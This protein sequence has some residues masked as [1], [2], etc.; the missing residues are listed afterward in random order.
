MSDEIHRVVCLGYPKDSVPDVWLTTIPRFLLPVLQIQSILE[1][2]T[3]SEIKASLGILSANLG[4]VFENTIQRIDKKPPNRRNAATQALMWVSHAGMPLQVDELCHALA[5]KLDGTGFDHDDLLPP[6]SIIECCFGLIVLDDESSTFR[7]VQYTLQDHLLSRGPQSFMQEETYIAQILITYVLFDGT[8]D[9]AIEHKGTGHR[10]S[11]IDQWVYVDSSLLEYAASNWGN[12]AQL[13]QSSEINEL[14]LAFLGDASKLTR[15]T[16]CQNDALVHDAG[17]VRHGDP[18][19]SRRRPQSTGVHVV[20]RYGLVELLGLLLDRGLEINARD[21]YKNTPLHDAAS[22]GQTD[23]LKVLLERGAEANSRNIDYDTPL[24]LAV[25]SSHELVIPILLTHGANVDD[26]RKDDWSPLHK[27]ADTGHIA[28]AQT[29]LNNGASVIVRSA[30]GLIPLHRAAGRGHVHMVQLLLHHGSP[31]DVATFDGW[32][33]LHGAS[34]S[35]QVDVAKILL[36]HDAEINKQS[37]DQRTALHRACRSGYYE[38]VSLLLAGNPISSVRD[39]GA[40]LPLHRAANGG[41][42]NICRLLLHHSSTSPLAQ[43]SSL[44]A[45]GRKPEKQASVSGHWKVAA[46]LRQEESLLRGTNSGGKSDLNLAVEA[47]HLL[48][49]MELLENGADVNVVSGDSST[50]IHQALLLRNESIAKVLLEHD[51]SINVPTSEGWQ[52]LHCAASKGMVSTVSL[53]LSRGAC[54]SARTLNGQTAL[55][56]GCKS[57]SLETVRVLIGSG[58]DVEAQDDCDWRPLHTASAAG[59]QDI[60]ELLIAN[61]ADLEARDKKI[62]YSASMC[63]HSW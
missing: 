22:H 31:V 40:N 36:N 42:E 48:R 62:P 13:S 29:L 38:F 49:V 55:H 15:A 60:V 27:A 37:S 24:Y 7:L 58:A 56:K 1:A 8:N 23:A 19:S 4:Q 32:T 52:P 45:N 2:M 26:H 11:N 9:S 61:D 54:I 41:H 6:R 63:C 18:W 5:T 14:A 46:F 59:F 25:S 51:A 47:G 39:C 28:I 57:G 35:G 53:C 50:P 3:K 33:P 16:Q 34:S 20:A 17:R 30:A 21:S 44:N 10:V 12:H 43:L